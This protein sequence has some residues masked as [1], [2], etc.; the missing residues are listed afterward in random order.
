MRSAAASVVLIS[1]ITFSTMSLCAATNGLDARFGSGGFVPLGPTPSS[2]I[3]I[4]LRALAVQTDGRILVGGRVVNVSDPGSGALLPAIGRLHADGSWDPSFGNHGVFVLPYATGSAPNGGE[5]HEIRVLS[6]N[7][8]VASGGSYANG[9][10]FKTCTL[11]VKLTDS[12]TLDSSFGPDQSG[13][14]CFDFATDTNQYSWPFHHEGL[15]LAADDSFYLT[16]PYTNMT[17]GAV[18]HFDGNGVLV[19]GYGA[20]GI[21]DLPENVVATRLQLTTEGQILAVGAIDNAAAIAV[22]RLDATGQLDDG[23]GASGVSQFDAQ[24][25]GLVS[26]VDAA[27]D[28][29][30]RLV[31]ADNDDS[32]GLLPY[33]FAR[34]GAGGALDDSFNGDAQQPGFPGFATP[35]VTTSG[36]FNGLGALH[37]LTDGHIFA[38]GDAGFL[39]DGDGATNLALLRLDEDSGYD[40]TFG[41]ALHPGWTSINIGGTANGETRMR[42]LAADSNQRTYLAI[43]AVDG[44]LHGCSG[45]VRI[46]PD[47]LNDSGF[48][49]TP[50]LPACPQ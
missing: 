38:V 43:D 29:Q 26:P 31:I 36:F 3:S 25:E 23:F 12:G 47:R 6:D 5:I 11:L 48:E 16:T 49:G 37:P 27:L 44:N 33:R 4:G 19:P 1:I 9:S 22:V 28:R 46:I 15:E 45:L 32:G 10:D 13:S 7:S 21:A 50:A 17:H 34:I 20:N 39:I 40:A 42:A 35:F 24:P 18:A 8:I 2:N 30:Q 41:D 14:F